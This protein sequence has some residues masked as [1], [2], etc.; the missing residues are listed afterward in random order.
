MAFWTEENWLKI[1]RGS[2]PIEKLWCF[3]LFL[4]LY[5]RS[6]VAYAFCQFEICIWKELLFHLN[7][8]FE[9]GIVKDLC[10]LNDIY[11]FILFYYAALKSIEQKT[12]LL[13][14]RYIYKI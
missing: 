14:K 7:K 6:S 3:F 11:S 9:S 8:D 4:R 2:L 10:F 1:G 13:I 12:P 5:K